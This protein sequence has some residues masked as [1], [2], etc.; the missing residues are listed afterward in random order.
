MRSHRR[1]LDI[2][3]APIRIRVKRFT[4]DEQ[5]AFTQAVARLD[6]PE[7]LRRLLVRKPGEEQEKHLVPRARPTVAI[8]L[9][10]AS[11]EGDGPVIDDVL[12]TFE[13]QAGWEGQIGAWRTLKAA[14]AAVVKETQELEQFVLPDE[15]I[16]RRRRDEMTPTE[17]EAFAAL[18]AEEASHALALVNLALSCIEVEPGQIVVEEDDGARTD[19]TTG[20]ALGALFAGRWPVMRA[21]VR[22]VWAANA[23]GGE[24]KN[25]SRSQSDSR[26]SSTAS[27]LAAAGPRPET[28]AADAAPRGSVGTEAAMAVSVGSRSGSTETLN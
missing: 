17:R 1:T 9:L 11:L 24:L 6:E 16:V 14:A 3:G 27:G 21:C 28:T 2:D 20:H 19:V 8:Q 12:K 25:A 15:E 26:R 13:S 5:A 4:H 22:E 10:T 23:L 18:E 7:S